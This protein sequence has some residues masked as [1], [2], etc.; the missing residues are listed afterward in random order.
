MVEAA[1]SAPYLGDSVSARPLNEVQ[2]RGVEIGVHRGSHAAE[3]LKSLPMVE[4][5]L[6]DP[7]RAY[8]TDG[9]MY[10]DQQFQDSAYSHV[11][12]SLANDP[13]VRI[14]RE[15]SSDASSRFSDAYFDFAYID[16]DHSYEAVSQD[17]R[18][19]WPKVRFRGVLAGDDYKP[20]FP[21]VMQA[22]TEFAVRQEIPLQALSGGQFVLHRTRAE[23]FVR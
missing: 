2:L 22:V 14:I 3:I 18:L 21:G 8:S 1:K 12:S 6:V 23:P 10:N 7:W 20:K 5:V 11:L 4:L 9:K 17:L 15:R 16:G 13:R 19:W